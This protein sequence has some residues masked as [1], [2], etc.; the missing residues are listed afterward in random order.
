MLRYYSSLFSIKLMKYPLVWENQ[1]AMRIIFVSFF[2]YFL[3]LA[4]FFF[5]FGPSNFFWWRVLR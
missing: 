4:F 2:Y 1:S 3:S 5:F